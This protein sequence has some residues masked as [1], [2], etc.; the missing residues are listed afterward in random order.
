MNIGIDKIGFYTPRIYVDMEK[1]AE[2]RGID[3]NKYTIGLGQE[4]MAVAPLSQDAV[5]MAA[6]AALG[7]LDEDDRQQIDMVLV[8]TESGVD[9]SKSVAVWV[10]QLTG[11]QPHARAVELKQACLVQQQVY[12]W[13]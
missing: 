2:E 9:H 13:R 1:L 5:T 12:N 4:Q 11:I 6:N 10:H 3:P 7:I 8:G